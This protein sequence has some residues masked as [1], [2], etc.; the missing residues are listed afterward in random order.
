MK[1]ACSSQMRDHH[2]A[3]DAG[4]IVFV[5]DFVYTGLQEEFSICSELR[6]RPAHQNRG[7]AACDWLALDRQVP[8]R[9][10]DLARSN[11]GF[12]VENAA[13][14]MPSFTAHPIKFDPPPPGYRLSNP[15]S[16][17]Y[18]GEITALH[19]QLLFDGRQYDT[20]GGAPIQTRNFLLR[21]WIRHFK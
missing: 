3:A 7:H 18:A 16:I 6:A 19:R 8:Q 2:T 14:L 13:V 12:Y 11:L 20:P 4:H 10:R 5:E 21:D 1:R 9:S 15:S 17:S